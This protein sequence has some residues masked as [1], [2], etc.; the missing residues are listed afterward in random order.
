LGSSKDEVL[1]LQG[2]PILFSESKFGYGGSE[3]YFQNDR[4]TGWKN[5]PASVAL[6]VNPH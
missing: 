1:V 3:I 4:V 5:D 2:T 6:R